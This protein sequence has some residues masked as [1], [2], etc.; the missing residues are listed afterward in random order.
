[1]PKLQST[2]Y[3]S[4][5]VVNAYPTRIYP[6]EGNLFGIQVNMLEDWFWLKDRY[7]TA[8]EAKSALLIMKLSE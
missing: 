7:I 1:M 2:W 6:A 8:H 4:D 3:L 5:A